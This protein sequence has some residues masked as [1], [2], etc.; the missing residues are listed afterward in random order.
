MASAKL[1]DLLVDI[2]SAITMRLGGEMLE[3]EVRRTGERVIIICQD[4]NLVCTL[5]DGSNGVLLQSHS[6]RGG[7]QKIVVLPTDDLGVIMLLVLG[8]R[9]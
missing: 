7:S 3:Y 8:A 6:L 5:Y 1:S 4:Y 2:I 9:K